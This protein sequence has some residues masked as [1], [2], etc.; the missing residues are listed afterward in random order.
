MSCSILDEVFKN[1]AITESS[2]KLY[3]SNLK[4]LNGGLEVK[5]FKFLANA[6]KVAETIKESKPNTQRNYYIVICSVLGELKKDNKKYQKLYDVYYKI[7]TQLNATLK[8]QTT[9]TT[10]ENENW[11]NKESIIAKLED[12][13]EILKE[14]TKKRK[15][16][17]EQ[18]E[19]LLDLIVLGLY[20]LMPPRRNIDYLNSFIIT[21]AYNAEEHGTEKNYV[22]LANKTFVFNNYKT[23]GT[24][25]TQIVPINEELFNIIKLYI[26]FR[27]DK[28]SNIPFLVDYENNPIMESNAI[29]KKLNAI[30]DG[31]KIG[32]SM[33][34][35][36]YLTDKY[37]D[38]I[39]NMKD[40]AENMGTSTGVMQTNYIKQHQ[41]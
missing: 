18:F 19:R 35:K 30:F 37:S 2:K 1:K 5:D 40:D 7:L 13:K 23:A 26:K 28:S 36:M 15:L 33:L 3:C 20:T 24:Y 34:R 39:E 12:K 11:L 27:N 38:V 8:D 29:T 17:K 14:I 25:K 22:D 41:L 6:D 21:N 32:S 4:R 16:N 10:T 31:K 9:K